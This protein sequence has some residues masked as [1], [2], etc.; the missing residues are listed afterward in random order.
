ME[1]IGW[2]RSHM[3]RYFSHGKGLSP[4]L[5]AKTRET[6]LVWLW[7]AAF[8]ALQTSLCSGDVKRNKCLLLWCAGS[9]GLLL[10]GLFR[11]LVVASVHVVASCGCSVWFSWGG[12]QPPSTSIL[13]GTIRSPS[14]LTGG[15]CPPPPLRGASPHLARAAPQ[16][17]PILSPLAPLHGTMGT[18]GATCPL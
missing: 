6:G 7:G 9:P 18:T 1:N 4:L 8:P 15:P 10:D 16:L 13:T 14:E 5:K 17:L 12:V 11:P 2:Q 3:C